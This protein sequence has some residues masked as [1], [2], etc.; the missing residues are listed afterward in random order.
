MP[1]GEPPDIEP[2]LAAAVRL[3]RAGRVREA[4]EIYHSILRVVPEH[5]DALHLLGVLAHQ[6]G[7][8]SEAVDLIGR[9]ISR[10]AGVAAFHNNLGNALHASKRLEEAERA[11]ERAL[12]LA[13]D[14]SEAHFNLGTSLA[15]QGRLT[16]A[17]A[18]YKRTLA[19]RPSH[20][21]AL[22]N[23]GNALQS[24]GR[25]EEATKAYRRALSLV[26]GYLDALTNLGNVLTARG[27]LE[28]A[29]ATHR[30]ALSSSPGHAAAHNNLGTVLARQERLEEAAAAFARALALEP[31]CVEAR[32]NL[33]HVLREQG[34][35]EQA[36][37]A[38]RLALTLLPDHPG[39][40]L[41]L[42]L[43][44][45]PLLADTVEESAAVPSQFARALDELAAWSEAHPGRLGSAAG[46]QQPFYLAYRPAD[47]TA[48]SCRYGDLIG[49]AAAAHWRPP[50]TGIL[51]RRV[52]Q[53]R[54]RV[55]VVSGQIRRHPVWDIILRGLITH[56]D[57]R[58]FELFVYHTGSLTDGETQWA[59]ANVDRFVQGPRP[60]GVWLDEIASDRPDVMLYPEVGMDP[61]A[62]TLAT[63]RLAG[64]QVASWGH[65]VTTGLPTMDA[66]FSGE[67]LEGAAAE[68]H[69]RERLIRLPGT[70][71]CTESPAPAAQ[72]WN[73][74]DRAAGVVRFALCQQPIK[75]DPAHDALFARVA[76]ECGPC[77]LWLPSPRKLDWATSRLRERL[78]AALRREGLD[79]DAHLRVMPWLTRECFA[80]FL[81]EMDIYLDSPAFSGYT[82]AWQAAH[83]GLPIVTRE[84]DFLRQRLAAGLLRQIG[85][86]EGIASSDDEYVEIAV[87]WAHECRAGR[88]AVRRETLRSAA[89][90]ADRN[91]AAVRAFEEAIVGALG[92]SANSRHRL[93]RL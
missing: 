26:P 92:A 62:C 24:L 69:Y 49:A 33:G 80:G 66:F 46:T 22:N 73:G 32:V 55:G 65:P 40:R 82:T 17:V 7:H 86:H 79:P 11:Y 41:G 51:S 67:Y 59:A 50:T 5:A 90:A 74:A 52:G 42:A 91:R 47:V 30:R 2:R 36:A 77:E 72:R 23:L 21:K 71:V 88:G 78:A 38:Y 14:Y 12:T 53:D 83:R 34:K 6:A 85:A 64:L 13:P 4:E 89:P 35:R 27:E 20:A 57:R 93:K 1:K 16:E 31:S 28:E 3:H 43:T 61:A 81:D 68:R 87:R 29:E 18:S 56:L 70:G 19:I 44:A 58:R 54:I 60:T 15:A 39:A 76:R 37:A 63:L 10:N 48:L 84:G 75:F 25:L 8:H 45:I 9:A